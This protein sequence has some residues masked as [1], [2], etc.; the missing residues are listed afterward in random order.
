MRFV[1]GEIASNSTGVIPA[2]ACLYRSPDGGLRG[3]GKK[4]PADLSQHL[5]SRHAKVLL[6]RLVDIDE[7]PVAIES[8]DC[9]AHPIENV[10]KSALEIA[11]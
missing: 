8:D 4:I 1:T 7:T 5:I 10:N 9:V 11:K 3:L 6:G 2:R